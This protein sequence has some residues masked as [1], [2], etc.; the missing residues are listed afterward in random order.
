ML[1]AYT[2]FPFK[3]RRQNID[4]PLARSA[5]KESNYTAEQFQLICNGLGE[6]VRTMVLIAMC[7]GLRVSE[8]LALKWADFDLKTAR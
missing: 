5:A 7:L 1:G 3:Q 8:I 6:P 2:M 4:V